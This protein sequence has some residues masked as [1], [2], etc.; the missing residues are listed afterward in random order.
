MGSKLLGL[1]G[2]DEQDPQVAA[3]RKHGAAIARLIETLVRAR[4][5]LGLRQV[6]VAKAMGTT[7]SAISNFERVGGDPKMST[8]LRYADAIGADVQFMVIFPANGAKA[9]ARI[10]AQAAQAGVPDHYRTPSFEVA[11]R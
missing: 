5:R 8:V 7:Q 4:E 11:V 6:Q 9:P 3:G 10:T 1:L 2:Y